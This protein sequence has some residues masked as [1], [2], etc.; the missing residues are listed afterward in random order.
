MGIKCIG[1]GSE[2]VWKC[3]DSRENVPVADMA[4][5]DPTNV[6]AILRFTCRK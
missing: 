4:F 5:I 1:G 3:F 2:L 6:Q